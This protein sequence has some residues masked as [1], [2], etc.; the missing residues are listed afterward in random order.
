MFQFCRN[1]QHKS[2]REIK[3]KIERVG[4][5]STYYPEGSLLPNSLECGERTA[6]TSQVY[7]F[8]TVIQIIT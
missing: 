5:L 6:P 3:Y 7:V 2:N 1:L 4:N 8:S